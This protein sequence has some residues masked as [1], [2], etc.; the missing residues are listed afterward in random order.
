MEET[1]LV[2]NTKYP[3]YANK[4]LRTEDNYVICIDCYHIV[5]NELFN[6]MFT[7]VQAQKTIRF[8]NRV[9]ERIDEYLSTLRRYAY[10]N[11]EEMKSMLKRV[12]A[13]EDRICIET[14]KKDKKVQVFT[15]QGRL[16]LINAVDMKKIFPEELS[17][18]QLE[19]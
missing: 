3:S 17:P 13:E 1:C 12:L 15:L 7:M 16:D 10:H 2:C 6:G 4:T 8:I 19:N 18:A 5:A 11:K 9:H 14:F